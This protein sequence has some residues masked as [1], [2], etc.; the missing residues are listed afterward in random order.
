MI[1]AILFD[2]DGVL[3]HHGP[4]FDEDW[5]WPAERHREVFRRIWSHPTYEGCLE[6]RG[7][8][9]GACAAVLAESG[10]VACGAD[11]Y[12]SR[13][14]RR[15][16][17]A[18]PIMLAWVRD[19]RAAGVACHLATNQEDVKAEYLEHELGYGKAFD[20]L[21][22][23]CRLGAAKPDTRFFERIAAALPHPPQAVAFFDDKAENVQAAE[24]VG[25]IGRR[26]THRESFVRDVTLLTGVTLPPAQLRPTKVR[27]RLF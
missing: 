9:T 15:G 3:Q 7:D 10:W 14:M 16:L 22:V 1:R 21:F 13:W 2:A 6:G 25:F 19:L 5:I 24:A 8:F 17:E 23:S 18:D 11:Q 12:L 27:P 26:F 4:F 20:S